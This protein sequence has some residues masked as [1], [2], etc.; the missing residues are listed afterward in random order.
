MA[1]NCSDCNPAY[2][3]YPYDNNSCFREVVVGATAPT[4]PLPAVRTSY[5]QYSRYGTVFYQPGFSVC[6][7][8]STY[9]IVT[10]N[11]I[12]A[13]PGLS[14]SQGP[15][16]RTAIWDTNALNA[17][18][19]NTW[20]GFS[21]CLSGFIGTKTYYVGIAADNEFRLVLDGVQILNTK[22]P[23]APYSLS[24]SAFTYWH[25]YPVEIG[26]GNHT[27]ELY[28]LNDPGGPTN[29]AGFGCEIYD[30][31]LA[32]LTGATS[33]S[34]LN[35]IFTTGNV[36]QFTLV[37]D[38]NGNYTSSGYTCPSGYVYSTCSG[39]C[40]SYQY[41][42][43][44][45]PTTTPSHTPTPTPTT[46]NTPQPSSTVTP[47]PTN[48][49]TP[50]NT[51]TITRTPNPT[52]TTTQLN[53]GEGIT[54]GSYYYTDCCG[55][56][57][58]GTQDGLP[59]TLDYSK[60]TNGV[61]KLYVNYAANCITPTPT[62]TSTT[63]STPAFTPTP[64][65]TPSA[66]PTLTPSITPTSSNLPVYQPQNDCQ[67]FTLFDLGVTCNVIAYPSSPSSNDGVLSLNVTGGTSPY[68]F[69]WNNGQR[70]QTLS[71]I[72]GGT[73]QCTVID[74]YRDYTATTVCGIFA[75]SATPTPT[76]TATPTVTPSSICP[77]LCFIA[78]SNN[79]AYGPWQFICNGMYNGKTTW[80]NGT[81]N[82]IWNKTNWEIVEQDMKTPFISDGGGIF[83]STTTSNVP[84][85]LWGVIGGTTT[86]GVTMTEGDCP[87]TL[88]LQVQVTYQ[89]ST[90]NVT[91]NGDGSITFAA[92]YGTPPYYY[93]I[94]NGLTFQ[95]SNFFFNLTPNTYTTIVKDSSTGSLSNVVAIGYNQSP[96]TYQ[97]SFVLVDTQS[98]VVPNSNSTTTKYTIVSTPAIPDGVTIQAN[99]EF[100]S[101]KIVD[102]PGGGT[103]TNSIVVVQ[104]GNNLIPTN[105]QSITSSATRPNCSPEIETT[106]TDTE[107]YSIT[108]TN[109]S[110]TSI[111]S[112]TQLVITDGQISTNSCVTE[113]QSKISGHITN[114]IISGCN[115]CSA[116]AGDT[117]NTIDTNV[118]FN[119][120][121][122]PLPTAYPI[123]LSYSFTDCSTACDNYYTTNLVTYYSLTNS[124]AIDTFLYTNNACTTP[125]SAGYYS[126]GA[127][128]LTINSVGK[129][130][131]TG[132]CPQ[133]Y[134]YDMSP[135]NGIGSAVGRSSTDLSF[136]SDATVA[137]SLYT[138][139]LVHPDT[140]TYAY[141]KPFTYN[142]DGVTFLPNCSDS[143]CVAPP[144]YSQWLLTYNNGDFASSACS[145]NSGNRQP[146]LYYTEA[147]TPLN[148]GS[149][150]YSSPNLGQ[151]TAS[152]GYYS[153]GAFNWEVVSDGILTNQTP[154]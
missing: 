57:V 90:C 68:S 132:P 62:P 19:I 129:I 17:T 1:Y 31:T 65:I 103:I 26:A 51:P 123:V 128:C 13:N 75:P 89:N 138:C 153:N 7:T 4:S 14:S 64:S 38:I 146:A 118:S 127:N 134:Y 66:T 80:S 143:N 151:S 22:T 36:T 24:L 10:T 81:Y 144:I 50:T 147:G 152:Q 56:F 94:N 15:L 98:N 102:G 115:C 136:I 6:G 58:Q 37:Q 85:A 61:T 74:Y 72:S 29:P 8:G 46:T 135:C 104:N 45:T 133:Y 53:C 3:W 87:A 121:A 140:G 101:I 48:T 59:I 63:T 113:L 92:L 96:V 47:T 141:N 9:G 76:V 84:T 44:P 148:N 2:T 25:V 83:A 145:G 108:L 18:P 12:W 120:S 86:Y 5:L 149:V 40:V 122:P 30:N 79:I 49:S 106:T 139:Y 27:L 41:C 130:T 34:D 109:T 32:Q 54:T 88:P 117:V 99:L 21:K 69:Y 126:Q 112:S 39:N 107:T 105:L 100:S 16:N 124:F 20:L 97:L 60:A 142:L 119:S 33:M 55:N 110:T 73:Y 77:K 70:S 114:P 43:A 67:V 125:V 95:N 116:I 150:L 28:G 11:N 93:S 35:I 111:V 154:C 131:S 78:I 23:P 137:V 52:P 82:I 71:G 42:V 91:Q